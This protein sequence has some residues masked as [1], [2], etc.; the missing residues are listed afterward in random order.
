MALFR[1]DDIYHI[2]IFDAVECKSKLFGV[3]LFEAEQ[4]LKTH[5]R[6]TEKW[7]IQCF[8]GEYITHERV[9][10]RLLI[11]KQINNTNGT[12]IRIQSKQYR[13]HTGY[14]S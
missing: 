1:P 6:D 14:A 9:I 8:T 13:Q 10:K 3:T 5:L 4:Y 12:N 2:G 11:L 7:V